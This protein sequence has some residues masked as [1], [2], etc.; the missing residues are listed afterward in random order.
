MAK[1]TTTKSPKKVTPSKSASKKVARSTAKKTTPKATAAKKTSKAP[2]THLAETVD[3]RVEK[4]E[5]RSWNVPPIAQTLKKPQVA[6]PIIALIILAL[7]AY[8]FRS[9]F[10]VATVNGQPITR[11]ALDSQLEQ[12]YGKQELDALVAQTLILQEA[13]KQHVTVSQ[14]EVNDS[15]KQISDTL[16]KQ[17]Q[18][19]D[20]VLAAR[21][22]SKQQLDDQ[23]RLQKTVEKLVGKNVTISDQEVQDYISKNQDSLP[24][25]L[26]DAELKQQVKQ[27]LMTQKINDKAQTLVQDLEKKAKVSYLANF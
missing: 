3:A 26:S 19:L 27:Q 15:E 25:G 2:V 16:A 5:S 9:W 13:N 4:N 23:I 8:I 11:T 20:A 10:V 22:M 12:Q 17:G 24:T 21:G 7:L 6:L 18:S 14:Q 1:K